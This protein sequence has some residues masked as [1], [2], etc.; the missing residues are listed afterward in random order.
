[1]AK[2][3][4]FIE[5]FKK[6]L[7]KIPDDFSLP[8][9]QFAYRQV[10]YFMGMKFSR[11]SGTMWWVRIPPTRKMHPGIHSA[12]AIPSLPKTPR[13]AADS[14]EGATRVPSANSSASCWE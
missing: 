12:R 9:W 3:D 5:D 10:N 4:A 11:I 8:Q 13:E 14:R 6:L 7:E 1:M 2:R